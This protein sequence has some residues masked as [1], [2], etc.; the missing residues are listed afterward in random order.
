MIICSHCHDT[1]QQVKG[2]ALQAGSQRYLCKVA[3]DGNAQ[4]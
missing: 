1:E 2:G 3:S 4:S